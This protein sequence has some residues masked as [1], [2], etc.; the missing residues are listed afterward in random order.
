MDERCKNCQFKKLLSSIY[1]ERNKTNGSKCIVTGCIESR[2][3]TCAAEELL[4][5]T[6][7]INVVKMQKEEKR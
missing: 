2:L 1:Y 4:Q 5:Q 7:T 3:H 6:K